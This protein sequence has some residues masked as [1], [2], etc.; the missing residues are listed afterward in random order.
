MSHSCIFSWPPPYPRLPLLL[1]LLLPLLHPHTHAALPPSSHRQPCHPHTVV[2]VAVWQLGHHYSFSAIKKQECCEYYQS[3]SR[4]GR[5]SEIKNLSYLDLILVV[6][7]EGTL[8]QVGGGDGEW[9]AMEG[10]RAVLPHE[11]T[12]LVP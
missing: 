5:E 10:D 3:Q 11:P 2:A 6:H 8:E 7:G 1:L 4:N 9:G 12:L